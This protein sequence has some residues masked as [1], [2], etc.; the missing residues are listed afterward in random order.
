VSAVERLLLVDCPGLAAPAGPSPDDGDRHLRELA[1]LVDALVEIC[2]WVDPVRPGVCTLA[3]RGPARYFGGEAA[4]LDAVATAAAGVLGD[5]PCRLGVAEGVF[6]AGLAARAGVVVAP[7]S[8]AG[9]LAPWPV[10]VLGTPELAELLPRLGLGTLGALAALPAADVLARFGAAG[11]RCQR[12]ARGLEGELPG[13]RTPGLAARLATLQYGVP[14]RNHQPGF[15]GGASAADGRAAEVLTD[16]QR[17][18]GPEAVVVAVD[19]GGRGPDDRARFVT[20]SAGAPPPPAAPA[21]P[22]PGQLPPP[23]PARVAAGGRALLAEVVDAAGEAV[24]VTGRGLLTARPA[25]LSVAGGP[26]AEVTG[27]SAPWPVEEGWWSRARRRSARLQVTT[28]DGR[29]HLL[30]VGRGRW[31]VAATYD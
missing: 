10:S 4:V 23:A 2:P 17:R 1:R 20:W 25:R 5:G 22:W 26:W 18:L 11:G 12:V 16:L 31:R 24:G 15:W 14:L 30:D 29:A 27:W 7:G 6:A 19:A 13:S 28:A 21:G 9:F 8:T 3:I